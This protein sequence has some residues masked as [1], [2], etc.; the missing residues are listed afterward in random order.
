[1]YVGRPQGDPSSLGQHPLGPF[2]SGTLGVVKMNFKMNG[3]P[4]RARVVGIRLIYIVDQHSRRYDVM[5][6]EPAQG[7]SFYGFRPKWSF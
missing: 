6:S 5:V 7:I 4:T 1:L 3:V 2:F